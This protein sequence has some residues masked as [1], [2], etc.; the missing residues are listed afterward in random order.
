M[1]ALAA[2]PSSQPPA[3]GPAFEPS[4][5]AQHGV[6]A[7]FR[8]RVAEFIQ[9]S[10]ARST[11]TGYQ[12][13]FR[14]F[15]GWCQDHNLEA[16]PAAP[17]TVAAYLTACADSGELK[18]A[19]IQRRVSAI[20]CYHSAAGHDSPTTKAVVKLTL[21]GIRRQLGT[22]QEG[23]AALLTAD[24]TAMVR[25]LPD[26]LL[27]IRD[28]AILLV[29]FAGAFRR[30]ELVGLNLQDIE[31]TADGSKVLIRR[32]KTDQEGHGQT[33]G[34]AR[35]Q[36]LCP[37]AA[38]EAWLAAA[39]ITSGPIFRRVNRHGHVLPGRLQPRAVAIVVQ[40]YASAA[41]LDAAR[42]GGHS[43]RAG[44]A[45]QAALN[46][47]PERIIQK[48]TRHKSADMLRRYIRDASLF[49]ENA[50]ARVGL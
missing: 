32:S 44:L 23:K 3:N 38:L 34:I 13:D 21:A 6:V 37:V 4:S 36:K 50:S 9:A 20:A 17:E 46:D 33:V 5:V 10:R 11:R 48:Q 24:L 8:P 30:S 1:S 7:Q 29:G 31:T 19:S 41:G 18:A 43:L 28:R 26:N 27:G 35:G 12:S 42:Y 22:H 40:R 47:V 14:H 49:R 39:G 25:R 2:A 15:A 45:T 16:L